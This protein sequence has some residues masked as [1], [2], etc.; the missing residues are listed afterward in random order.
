[1]SAYFKY[2]FVLT[3]LIFIS[4]SF[5]LL[6][7]C[8]QK[9]N[10]FKLVFSPQFN[11]QTIHCE[12]PFQHQN[13]AWQLSQLQFF[14]SNV[15]VKSQE[16]NWIK[17]SIIHQE[18]TNPVALIGTSCDS[19]ETQNSLW[20]TTIK[21]PFNPQKITQI[22]FNLGVP[23]NLNHQNPL[24]Q[25]APLNQSDMFWVWQTGHKFLR[26][27]LS[28]NQNN[29]TYHLGS[30]GCE[31]VSPVRAPKVECKNPNR[32]TVNIEKFN[33][34]NPIIFD[35]ATLISDLDLTQNINCKSSPNNPSCEPLML[36]TGIDFNHKKAKP[37]VFRGK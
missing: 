7:A 35:V 14:I 28:N 5:F 9:N 31:S 24:T 15:Q 26:L 8:E 1:M 13:Q 17:A 4:I 16:N 25:P 34:N 18:K 6:A 30:T 12:Q 19:S 36:R 32:T 3:K 27:E 37:V 22:Q 33:V 21:A 29:F 10:D 23:F 11:Q 20:Q 2:L